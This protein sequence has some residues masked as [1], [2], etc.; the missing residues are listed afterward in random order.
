[1]D[2]IKE[3]WEGATPMNFTDEKWSY[4][5]KRAF[6]Y[7]LQDY[8]HGTFGFENWKGKKVL[9]VGCGSGIDAIEFARTRL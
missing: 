6:R 8:M 4:K 2:K 7:E 5:R 9:E 3:Y 1:M